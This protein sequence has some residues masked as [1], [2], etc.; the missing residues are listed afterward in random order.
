MGW[1]NED[2][3]GPQVLSSCPRV[4]LTEVSATSK[5]TI[6]ASKTSNT[7]NA[8]TAGLASQLRS[9]PRE[10]VKVST[11]PCGLEGPENV[12]MLIITMNLLDKLIL[13]EVDPRTTDYESWP[14]TRSLVV[15]QGWRQARLCHCVRHQTSESY[16]P[17]VKTEI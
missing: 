6:N 11:P 10:S 5:T 1:E 17:S 12:L 4:H 7:S 3:H 2:R 9:V 13:R 8:K 16:F 14:A 15:R